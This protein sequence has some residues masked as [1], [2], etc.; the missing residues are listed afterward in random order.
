MNDA[1]YEWFDIDDSKLRNQAERDFLAALVAHA[2][3]RISFGLDSL[4]GMFNHDNVPFAECPLTVAW[5]V[6]DQKRNLNLRTLRVD[7]YGAKLVLGEDETGSLNDG[8]RDRITETVD[9]SNPGGTPQH[10]AEVAAKWLNS[11]LARVI[12]RREWANPSAMFP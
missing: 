12:E 3:E 7:F 6:N 11:E 5:S 2:P 8:F 10:F 9:Y 4:D 1:I